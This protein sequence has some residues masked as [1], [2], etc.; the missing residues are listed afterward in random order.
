MLADI[1]IGEPQRPVAEGCMF[2]VA[3]SITIGIVRVAIYFYDQGFGGTEEV[4]DRTTDDVLA[5]ELVSAQLRSAEP[6]PEPGF[7]GRQRVAVLPGSFDQAVV[8]H[9][10][11]H[12][13][14]LP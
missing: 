4:H 12:P 13:Q 7:E 6:R 8:L 2:P 10:D 3:S 5:P 14:P 11:P 9:L 1:V